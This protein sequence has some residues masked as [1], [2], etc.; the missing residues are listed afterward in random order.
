[1]SCKKLFALFLVFFA[2]GAEAQQ[3]PQAIPLS[4]GACRLDGGAGCGTLS[5]SSAVS[6][7][8]DLI[9]STRG[10]I[11]YRGASGWAGLS[12]G[13]AT[14]VLTSNGAGA[15]PSWQA[16]AAS[17]ATPSLVIPATANIRLTLTS[18]T[19]V[20]TSD[21]TAATTIYVTPYLG[22]MLS[23][24]YSSAW[25]SYAVTEK[26]VL[27]TASQ[28][29]TTTNGSAVISGLTDTSQ[30]V[31]GMKVTGTNVG[32]AAV[33]NSVDSA[34]QVTVSVNST[35]SA[36]NTITFKLPASKNYDVFAVPTSSSAYRIQLGPAWTSDTARAS[37]V[38][39]AN[40]QDGVLVNDSIIA[41][42]DSNSI[43]AKGGRYIGTIRTT[44]TDGQTEDS[45]ANRLV[46]S[47]FNRVAKRL[48]ISQSS[49]H[50]Y[51][52]ASFRSWNNST[53]NRVTFVTG[54]SFDAFRAQVRG[55]A[56]AVTNQTW[57]VG[58]GLDSTTVASA[59]TGFG[60]TNLAYALL[61]GSYDYAPVAGYHYLQ[62]L[63]YGSSS[64]P[65]FYSV[66]VM[67]LMLF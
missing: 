56:A 65:T 18:G 50:T 24:Y 66:D 9:T 38:T 29:G 10:S 35:G 36:S 25:L 53:A 58:L 57:Y 30:L 33:I 49:T 47:M 59:Q 28:T 44:A 21:V 45:E 55:D 31:R 8:L 23:L 2:L 22:A 41:S 12:P 11:F 3:T 40:A 48:Y 17:G 42:G 15:D 64:N 46:W 32:A 5:T 51:N 54:G 34:T 62:A 1:M 7:A 43:A 14:Y 27:A 13:T 20:T 4:S 39:F 67:S 61:T 6:A 19:P 60:V 37:A 52:S 16:S 63:E 26:S